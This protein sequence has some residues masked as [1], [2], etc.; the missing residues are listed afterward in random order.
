DRNSRTFALS[1]VQ[2]QLSPAIGNAV[3]AMAKW[4]VPFPSSRG[5]YI[6][7]TRNSAAGKVSVGI[8]ATANRRT[9]QRLAAYYSARARGSNGSSQVVIDV[10]RQI[11]IGENFTA[12]AMEDE[13]AGAI[14]LND[15][16]DVGRED[17]RAVGP[18][19]EK[20]LVRP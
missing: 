2:N 3:S 4:L 11:E 8:N 17:H 9:D 7:R 15:L 13:R 10:Q 1:S 6:W 5:R 16:A 18:L 12:P 20:F 19:F 14:G